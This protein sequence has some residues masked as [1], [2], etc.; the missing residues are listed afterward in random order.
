M[1]Q[2]E[3]DRMPEIMRRVAEELG[4]D[5]AVRLIDVL[6][7]K[8]V[9]VPSKAEGSP[10]AEQVGIEIATVLCEEWPGI[11]IE[12][13]NGKIWRAHRRRLAILSNPRKTTNELAEELG[14]TTRQVRYLR[15]AQ[16]RAVI[17]AAKRRRQTKGKRK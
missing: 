11:K 4:V 12:V 7:G 16:R 2:D 14:V 8:D 15:A 6:G 5:A 1:P 13:P 3:F 17:I 10:L 9:F